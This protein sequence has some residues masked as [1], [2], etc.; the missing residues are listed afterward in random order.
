M[1]CRKLIG[2]GTECFVASLRLFLLW[3]GN[4]A[5]QNTLSLSQEDH[6]RTLCPFL[7]GCGAGRIQASS[8][9]LI[10][11]KEM[12]GLK[13]EREISIAVLGRNAILGLVLLVTVAALISCES[14]QWGVTAEDPKPSQQCDSSESF[15]L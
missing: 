7:R 10:R 3:A 1:F 11:L 5:R 12:C 6:H 15:V 4:P 9:P 2:K 13:Q 14:E 8:T